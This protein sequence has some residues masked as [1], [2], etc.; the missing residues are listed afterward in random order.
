MKNT[1]PLFFFQDQNNSKTGQI[2]KRGMPMKDE[3]G[4]YYRLR[5]GLGEK[6]TTS[7]ST[8][9]ARVLAMLATSGS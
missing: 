7:L 2:K 4:S 9:A 3:G 5:T 8:S 1:K 6:K